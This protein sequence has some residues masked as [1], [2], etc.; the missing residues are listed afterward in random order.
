[1]GILAYSSNNS[2][3]SWWLNDKAWEALEAAGWTVHWRPE[4]YKPF[5]QEEKREYGD[6]YSYETAL[7][8]TKNPG[9]VWLGAKATSAAKEFDTPEEGV[10]EWEHI[11][12]ETAGDLGCGCCGPPHN[13]T[14]FDGPD[15]RTY[16][17]IDE[18]TTVDWSFS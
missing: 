8:K 5:V 6:S 2:G 11:T 12:G 18:P 15:K 14:F 3:G 16:M 10:R 7:I 9:G 13:F 17:N 1:M 4:N